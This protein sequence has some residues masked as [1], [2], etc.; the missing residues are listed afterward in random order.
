MELLRAHLI[1]GVPFDIAARY[2]MSYKVN[3]IIE[4][5]PPERT[6]ILLTTSPLSVG[7]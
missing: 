3:C 4:A 6:G 7:W 5:S 2:T 1:I